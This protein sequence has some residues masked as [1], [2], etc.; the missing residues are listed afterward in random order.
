MVSG[1][2]SRENKRLSLGDQE[3]LGDGDPAVWSWVGSGAE[4]AQLWDGPGSRVFGA[5]DGMTSVRGWECLQ[6]GGSWS[7]LLDGV[8]GSLIS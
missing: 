1:K 2:G 8:A 4:L 7:L 6:D 5:G 3:G